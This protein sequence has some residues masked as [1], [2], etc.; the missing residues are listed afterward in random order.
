MHRFHSSILYLVRC[1]IF[2]AQNELYMN[3]YMG[4]VHVQWMD[5]CFG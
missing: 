1:Y 4:I 3:I 5:N 2:L